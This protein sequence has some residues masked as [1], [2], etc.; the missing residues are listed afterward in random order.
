MWVSLEALSGF[1]RRGVSVC[2][3]QVN[4]H[5]TPC[6]P[7]LLGAMPRLIYSRAICSTVKHSIPTHRNRAC[8]R[9]KKSV[10]AT[11]LLKCSA[12]TARTILSICHPLALWMS[13]LTSKEANVPLYRWGNWGPGGRRRRLSNFHDSRV[14]TLEFELRSQFRPW[15]HDCSVVSIIPMVPLSLASLYRWGNW[16]PRISGDWPKVP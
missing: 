1:L 8:P 7:P 15:T 10:S 14:E 6:C 4:K 2:Y 3:C 9:K 12:L 11:K 5:V 16:D 13:M